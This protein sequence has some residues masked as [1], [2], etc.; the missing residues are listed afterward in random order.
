[1]DINRN[2]YNRICEQWHDFRRKTII[3]QCAADF[4][5]YLKP[6]SNILDIGC[7][8]GYPIAAYLSEQG[9][10]VTGIDIS[11]RMIEKAKELKLINATFFIKDILEFETAE[12]YD[13]VIAFDSLWYISHDKQAEIYRI[14]SSLMNVGGYFLFTHGKN[15][16]TIMGKMFGEEF[17]YSALDAEDVFKILAKNGFGVISAVEDY[18]EETTGDRELLVI[19]QKIS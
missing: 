6:N 1:M 11:E 18:E 14:V 13:G 9:F 3:N 16:G 8:T 5:K 4:I 7:G 15:N 10:K 19:A 2:S 17:C 12:K